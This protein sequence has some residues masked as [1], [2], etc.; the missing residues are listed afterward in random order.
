MAVGKDGHSL[1]ADSRV[2]AEAWRSALLEK[3][4]A[5][6][7]LL[8]FLGQKAERGLEVRETEDE[9]YGKNKQDSR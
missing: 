5:N 6:A 1:L 2:F 3:Q 8:V 9:Q 4:V 7:R